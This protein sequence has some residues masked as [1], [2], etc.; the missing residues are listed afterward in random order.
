MKNL[1]STLGLGLAVF[2]LVLS[3]SVANAAITGGGNDD[4]YRSTVVI[5]AAGDQFVLD[6]E[7]DSLGNL[8][9]V[10][11][12]DNAVGDYGAYLSKYSP[13]GALIWSHDLQ[14]TDELNGYSLTVDQYDHVYLTGGFTGT[15]DFDPGPGTD[16]RTAADSLGNDSMDLYISKFAPDGTIEWTHTLGADSSEEFGYDISTDGDGL[17]V[18]GLLNDPADF[19]PGPGTDIVG[20]HGSSAGFLTRYDLDGTYRWTI[21]VNDNSYGAS[22]H[23]VVVQGGRVT[24]TGI[25]RG[26]DVVVDLDP[27]VS[28]HNI[29]GTGSSNYFV[30]QYDENGAFRWGY[31]VGETSDSYGD[32]SVISDTVGNVYIAGDFVNDID[33][34][35]TAN[36]DIRTPTGYFNGFVSK[37]TSDGV[38][39]WTRTFE[40][41]DVDRVRGLD[42]DSTAG[43]L[44]LT[45]E[46]R[47][48]IDF[49]PGS[50]VDTHTST[51]LGPTARGDT[52]LVALDT[53]G[54]FV[55]AKSFTGEQSEYPNDVTI[56]SDGT[57]YTL[58][59]FDGTVDFDPGEDADVRNSLGGRDAAIVSF[60]DGGM[61][62]TEPYSECSDGIDNDGDG[63]VDESDHGCHDDFDSEDW[64]SYDGNLNDES[65]HPDVTFTITN[66]SK[67]TSNI[68]LRAEVDP[69]A[70][71]GQYLYGWDWNS[72]G[73]FDEL[74][75]L[76]A[77]SL[78][79]ED[80][81][82][83]SGE[84]LVD[85]YLLDLS[86]QT[87]HSHYVETIPVDTN[88]VT[89][90][91]NCLSEDDPEVNLELI[92][93]RI[94]DKDNDGEID[95]EF[96]TA[97]KWW[98]EY[99]DEYS[100]LTPHEMK[101]IL[102]KKLL[103]DSD[104]DV[105]FANTIETN[106]TDEL[107]VD[108]VSAQLAGSN[109]NALAKR[110]AQNVLGIDGFGSD[111]PA[112]DDI[113]DSLGETLSN[114]IWDNY[115]V[116][117]VADVAVGAS[118][119]LKGLDAVGK[120][121]TILT[122]S[123]ALDAATSDKFNRALAIY[124]NGY[125]GVTAGD[126]QALLQS[127]VDEM[128]DFSDAEK[129]E[130]KNR[131]KSRILTLGEYYGPHI[132]AP[133]VGT[134]VLNDAFKEGLRQ[135]YEMLTA[136]AVQTYTVPAR[137][138]V[139]VLSPVELCAEDQSGFM[140]GLCDGVVQNEIPNTIYDTVNEMIHILGPLTGI[141]FRLTGT[142]D[143]EYGVVA[144]T[145]EGGTEHSFYLDGFPV[146]T[147]SIHTWQFEEGEADQLSSD[148]SVDVDGDGTN[149][150]SLEVPDEFTDTV[151][152]S[153]TASLTGNQID[154]NAYY[155]SVSV[156]LQATDGTDGSG[157]KKIEYSLDGVN[158]QVYDAPLTLDE[159]KE[160]TVYYRSTD[161]FENTE[162]T[163]SVLCSVVSAIGLMEEVWQWSEENSSK[164]LT[165]VLAES[166][167]EKFWISRNSLAN[168]GQQSILARLDNALRFIE[169]DSGY[170]EHLL[171]LAKRILGN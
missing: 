105:S 167:D 106:I 146:E 148:V 141:T 49:D 39:L 136:A 127:L 84:R 29:T 90:W 70:V 160:Y 42:V 157:V 129:T 5:G 19:D 115:N 4:S 139:G 131:L 69:T 145:T 124:L 73:I 11:N 125:I 93:Q 61:A 33:F 75:T 3:T 58:V 64:Y 17:Y 44:Y 168:A 62:I 109:P 63:L 65:A 56:G 161:W 133:T 8:Y 110:Y 111:V 149:E 137:S 24:V 99:W 10:G 171:E 40:N 113:L 155:G 71:T 166:L 2:L 45:G 92:N 74:S 37:Y 38:Y 142:A 104:S 101:L 88:F 32:S 9:V 26:A 98:W 150:T 144:D 34:D 43:V 13:A 46:Y 140:T 82:I 53:E 6:S 78:Q 55:F 120:I 114:P 117:R 103:S 22:F 50:G 66:V 31:G 147:G 163:Q 51:V 128:D 94:L 7:T 20:N 153:T 25:A 107:L 54:D 138:S 154:N 91:F 169:D 83:E 170:Y 122:L 118:Y 35:P 152:P 143:D 52:F 18:V 121:K 79:Y 100:W 86:A 95:P 28:T 60:N 156:S 81:C 59:N 27:G 89:N 36:E 158:W 15:A 68:Y 151:A 12:R 112:S 159:E 23:S 165:K 47:G 21:A 108:E 48:V 134:R 57:L 72:D 102:S 123:D 130:V 76:K 119:A 96:A 164:Q 1:I 162:E 87:V 85:L 41:N 16:E 77:A 80:E 116:G 30:V 14:S 67:T 135:N 126:W 132:E 97:D